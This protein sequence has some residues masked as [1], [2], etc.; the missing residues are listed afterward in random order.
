MLIEVRY[1]SPTDHHIWHAGL[2]EAESFQAATAKISLSS[3]GGKIKGASFYIGNEP[4][5]FQ[6]VKDISTHQ[7]GKGFDANKGDLTRR[8]V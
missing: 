5:S 7:W 1:Y 3:N 4:I 2:I 6:E 8:Y